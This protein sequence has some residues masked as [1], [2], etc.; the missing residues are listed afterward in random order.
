MGNPRLHLWRRWS[1]RLGRGNE[2]WFLLALYGVALLPRLVFT[3][4]AGRGDLSLDEIEYFLIARNLAEGHGYRWYFDLPCTFRPPGY[5]FFL[6]G[7]CLTGG[8]Q[9]YVVRLLQTLLI[10]TQPV[11]T[12]LLARR[13]G[14]KGAARMAGLFVAFYPPL[15]LYSV[16]LMPENVFISLLLASLLFLDKAAQAGLRRHTILAGVSLAAA[17]LVRPSFTP[18]LA[19]LLV[20]FLFRSGNVRKTAIQWTA[21]VGIVAVAAVPWSIR[22]TLQAGQFVFLDST[23]GYNLYV[24]YNPRATGTFDLAV[25]QDLVKAFIDRGMASLAKEAGFKP[26]PALAQKLLRKEIFDYQRPPGEPKKAYF[27]EYADR[28]ESDV[29][30]HNTGRARAVEFMREHPG[31]ALALIPLKF[32]HFWNLEHRI[33][34][35]AYSHDFIGPVPAVPLFM[36]FFLLLA[37]FPLLTVGALTAIVFNSSWNRTW[38]LI[39]LP[40]GY[41]T[42]LHSLT[43]GDAR[44]HYPIVPLLAILAAQNLGLVPR[45]KQASWVRKGVALFLIVLFASIWAYGLCASWPQWQ[46]VLGPNGNQSNLSF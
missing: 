30:L 44:F 45:I 26:D 22:N 32:M 27:R 46:A 20:W 41:L 37:P 9:Y 36:L 6:A 14:G 21:I 28:I 8:A 38:A 43:F 2:C 24:G 34:L 18:F 15:V 1:E 17:I 31:R 35:F 11:L 19:V 29:Y 10:A 39:L 13:M 25:A 40:M 16:A 23:A 12:Y 33:F 7:L 42:V 3:A 5:P 4:V